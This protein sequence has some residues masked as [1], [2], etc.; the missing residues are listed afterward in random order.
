MSPVFYKSYWNVLGDVVIE[1]IQYFFDGGELPRALNPHIHHSCAK[2]RKRTF[3][4]DQN[5]KSIKTVKAAKQQT[6]N[7]NKKR[8][9]IEAL[10]AAG[11][12]DRQRNDDESRIR[13]DAEQRLCHVD[14]SQGDEQKNKPA[15]VTKS[16]ESRQTEKSS[17]FKSQ[18]EGERIYFKRKRNG[19][20]GN[21]ESRGIKWKSH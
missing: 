21:E 18:G 19:C 1:A 2:V 16:Q 12:S 11:D 20:I 15:V 9:N 8:N 3:S 14:A 6:V 10:T 5:R 13:M 7:N 17:G 4:S